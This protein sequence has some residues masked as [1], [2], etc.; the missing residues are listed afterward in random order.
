MADE[1]YE[2]GPDHLAE[3]MAELRSKARAM[4]LVSHGLGTIKDL[5]DEA[6]WIDKGVKRAQGKPDDVVEQYLDFMQARSSAATM[7]DF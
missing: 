1:E 5:C 6:I 2:G 7:E 3:K 4:F